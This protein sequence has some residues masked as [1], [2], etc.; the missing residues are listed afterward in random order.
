MATVDP[1]DLVHALSPMIHAHQHSAA[2]DAA[3]FSSTSSWEA[4]LSTMYT[5][6]PDFVYKGPAH[7]HS[8]PWFGSP[9]PYLNLVDG[10]ARSI[11]PN[12]KA[13]GG[14]VEGA[15]NTQAKDQLPEIA[16]K[17]A[18]NCVKV[19]DAAFLQAEEVGVLPGFKPT[20]GIL[21]HRDPNIPHGSYSI[22]TIYE[23]GRNNE[24]LLNTI[25]SMLMPA[26]LYALFSV[27][28]LRQGVY[29]EDIEDDPVGVTV[30]TLRSL[31]ARLGIFS[32]MA[33]IALIFFSG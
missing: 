28:F 2:A 17:A 6:T 25:Q 9:D 1:T 5:T 12:L 11:A 14:V 20:G 32:A 31:G 22:K 19:I 4:V 18:E 7:G 29:K 27:A 21:P 24:K 16:Q 13:L 26:A 10:H 30:E 15:I 23:Q 3:S 33:L 8:N